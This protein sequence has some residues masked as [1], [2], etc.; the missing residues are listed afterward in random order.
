MITA[1][2]VTHLYE[3]MFEAVRIEALQ[4]PLRPGVTDDE[5]DQEVDLVVRRVL[6]EELSKRLTVEAE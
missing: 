3:T 5:I 2:F 1:A 6:T 4:W